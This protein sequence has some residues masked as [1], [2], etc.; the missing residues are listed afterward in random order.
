MMQELRFIDRDIL[1]ERVDRRQ[2]RIAAARAVAAPG[3]DERQE[4]ANQIRIEA[5]DL[6]V[7]LRIDLA[8]Q[9][10]ASSG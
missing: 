8:S 9:Q 10:L 7:D 1:E 6:L 4:V 3:L 2:T 5:G